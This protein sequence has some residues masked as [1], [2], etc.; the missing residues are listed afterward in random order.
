ME[1]VDYEVSVIA[2]N[3]RHRPLFSDF[4]GPA[5]RHQ[6]RSGRDDLG[7]SRSKTSQAKHLA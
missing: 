3:A 2:N 5:R 4:T 7:L 6:L 1:S